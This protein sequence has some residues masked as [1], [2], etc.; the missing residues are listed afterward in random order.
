MSLIRIDTTA[1][2]KDGLCV[3][4]CPLGCLSLG[5][6]GYPLAGHEDDCIHCG[7][8]VAICPHK[9]ISHADLP[10]DA[11]APVA[12]NGVDAADLTALL[13][14]RR[15]VRQY[16]KKPL[17]DAELA[18]LIEV[19]RLAPTGVNSQKLT[20][21][22]V[23]HEAARARII[24]TSMDWLRG[25]A[26][27]SYMSRLIRLYDQGQDVVL[28]GA[29]NLLIA[30]APVEYTWNVVDCSIA[31]T[32]VE[33]QA[34]AMGLGACWAGLVLAAMAANPDMG[35]GLG[36]PDDHKACAALML[37]HPRARHAL[38]PPRNQARLLRV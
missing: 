30:C 25:L 8:C 19:G 23:E 10:D 5:E 20:W 38:I 26:G 36:I 29:P 9:A 16:R 13:K 32:Y 31:M 17:S 1:C 22:S 33:I 14:S 12:K 27:H 6:D 35:R 4:A 28:R 3:K 21:V 2:A 37:G 11:F 24:E 15:S 34:A 7:H 18:A